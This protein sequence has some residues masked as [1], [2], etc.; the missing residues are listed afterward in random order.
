MAD[1]VVLKCE[2]RELFQSVLVEHIERFGPIDPVEYGFIEEMASSYWRLR[3]LWAIENA[4]VDEGLA[5]EPAGDC[6]VRMASALRKL[7]GSPELALI[8]RYETRLQMMYQRAL[9]NILVMRNAGLPNEPN[10]ISGQLEPDSGTGDRFSSP[11]DVI[12]VPL[13]TPPGDGSE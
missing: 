5:A 1:L 8:H 11:V 3:R 6:S 13:L 2:S 4:V 12:D 7:T 10:P 9:H